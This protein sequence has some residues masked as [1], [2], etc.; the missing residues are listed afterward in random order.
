MKALVALFV[1]HSEVIPAVTAICIWCFKRG[2]VPSPTLIHTLTPSKSLA[3]TLILTQTTLTLTLALTPHT[4]THLNPH[5]HALK[6]THTLTLTHS[7]SPLPLSLTW[8]KSS[9]PRRAPRTDF[10]AQKTVGL[11]RVKRRHCVECEGKEKAL[12]RV[13]EHHI[14]DEI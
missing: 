11:L 9:S 14:Q 5:S 8:K 10:L 13:K 7:S 6:V 2:K 12:Y 3:L 1:V 4:Y